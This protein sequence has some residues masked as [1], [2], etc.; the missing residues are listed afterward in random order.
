MATQYS[1]QLRTTEQ[2]QS[3][4]P[5]ELSD[6]G[7]VRRL[8]FSLNTS[9]LTS[10]AELDVVR[11]VRI[12]AGSRIY[13]GRVINEAIGAN[14]VVDIGLQGADGTGNIDA[15]GAVS[16]DP[17]FFTSAQ[18]AVATVGEN[19]FGILQEDNPTYKAEKD[20]YLTLTFEDTS[21]NV[22]PAA[23]KDITG[24]VDIVNA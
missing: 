21:S 8:Y 13:G 24:Y 22:A 5:L 17:D 3:S 1:T 6:K 20:L 7:Q 12:P 14:Q 23:D 18:L 9:D 10:V 2:A 15:A 19:S 4:S 16:D 11:L